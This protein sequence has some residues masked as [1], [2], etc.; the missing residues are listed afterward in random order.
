[1]EYL[2]EKR[3]EI[4]GEYDRSMAYKITV[5]RFAM[6]Q[7]AFQRYIVTTIA[8]NVSEESVVYISEHT[9]ELLGV[10]VVDD[11]IRRYNDSIYFSSILGYTGKISSE[12]YAK[13]SAEDDSYTLNDVIGKGGI[14]QYMDSV[15]KGTSG[16]EKLYVDHMGRVLQVIDYEEPSSGG[17]V[18]VSI[19]ADLQIAV[20][21]LLEQEIAGIVYSN[22]DNGASDIPIPITDVYYAL[23]YNNV[24]DFEEF[25]AADASPAERD[26][27][28]AAGDGKKQAERGV[29]RACAD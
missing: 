11:T 13:L 4:S 15:L 1:M 6:S 7:N 23:I 22:I 18:Y 26:V 20:Y 29:K 16:Y 14:E 19:D 8:T 21:N 10:E 17:N 5:V 3:Y 25:E 9:D 24:I 2:S 28:R 12:E 27:F